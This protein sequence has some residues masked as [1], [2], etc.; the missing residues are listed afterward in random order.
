MFKG[1]DVSHHQGN[2]DWGVVSENADFAIIRM[3]NSITEDRRFKENLKGTAKHYIPTMLYVYSKG[4]SLEKLALE[5]EAIVTRY[6]DLRIDPQTPLFIDWEDSC[7]TN[8]TYRAQGNTLLLYLKK[9]QN[10]GIANVGWYSSAA[11]AST[12]VKEYPELALMP[13]WIAATSRH[14][15]HYYKGNVI[16]W[17][18]SWK[19][20]IPG[21]D[22]NV[23]LDEYYGFL[24]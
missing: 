15:S 18:H 5:T 13:L 1:I 23:D 3:L 24:K 9:L 2:I 17:Q 16:A 14:Y 10:S 22:T 8:L 6:K 11:L 20:S 12:L 21:I 7:L 4:D 19:G